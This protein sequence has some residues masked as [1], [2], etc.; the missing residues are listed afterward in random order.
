MSPASY[1]YPF[2]LIRSLPFLKTLNSSAWGVCKCIYSGLDFPTCLSTWAVQGP[3]GVIPIPTFSGTFLSSLTNEVFS[4]MAQG[5]VSL[6]LQSNLKSIRSSPLTQWVK[7]PALSL[8]WHGFDH[9]PMNFRIPWP[10]KLKKKIKS[11]VKN[12]FSYL[13]TW[14]LLKDMVL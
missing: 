3:L 10:K 12:V 13:L 8:L 7:E 5:S 2:K 11:P 9:W 14:E 6:K 4:H 1:P